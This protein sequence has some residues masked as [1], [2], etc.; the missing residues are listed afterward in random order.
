MVGFVDDATGS[1]NDF[2][3]QTQQPL[4]QLFQQMT[5]DA[6]IWNDLLYC[7][8]GKLELSKC[9]FHLLHFD[10]LP[11]GRPIPALNSYSETI[12]LVDAVT[13][14]PT[15]ITSKRVFEPH[16]TLGHYKSPARNKLDIVELQTKARRLATLIAVSPITRQG[17]RLAYHTVFVPTIRYTLPQ[18]FHTRSTLDTAQA[19][20]HSR[21]IAKCGY[22]RHMARAVI[23]APMCYAG[24]EF[25]PWYL[26]QGEGQ[27]LNFIK[28]WR[29]DTMISKAL[30][31]TLSWAQ[32]QSGYSLPLLEQVH[33]SIPHLECRW[34]KSLRSFLAAID[35]QIVTN[36]S[37]V[38][39]K[40]TLHDIYIM[41]YAQTCGLFTNEDMKILNYCRLY[42]H[43]VTVSELLD[44]NGEDIIPHL[45]HCQREPWFNNSS[46]TTLQKRPSAHQIKSKWQRLCRQWFTSQ[47]KIAQ[48]LNLG[49]WIIPGHQLRRRRQAYYDPAH[50]RKVYQWQHNQYWEYSRLSPK[51]LQYQV[52]GPSVHFTS[53]QKLFATATSLGTC[54]R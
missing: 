42:L 18:S 41:E 26:L 6:Q 1:C 34:L 36:Q 8:G 27:I 9:S 32:W 50:P 10:F 12:Q 49:P 37:F 24:G 38:S 43:I 39:R 4:P 14:E 17:A 29:T 28:H 11:S 2:S 23:Y 19:A 30:R 40:E 52:I 20:I 13:Q 33:T 31:I 53:S 5:R 46:Y 44:A 25:I 15:S 51:S 54:N 35:S 21:I 48:S 22:N 16:K 45:F 3:P 7:S 47:G